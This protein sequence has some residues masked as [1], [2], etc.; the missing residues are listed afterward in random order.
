M[1]RSLYFYTKNYPRFLFFGVFFI[2]YKKK[3]MEC[4]SEFLNFIPIDLEQSDQLLGTSLQQ[5]LSKLAG[6]HVCS[7]NL[8]WEILERYFVKKF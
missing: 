6:Y 5:Y 4:S 1:K 7:F 8:F 3:K 2:P